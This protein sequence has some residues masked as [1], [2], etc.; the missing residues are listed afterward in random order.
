MPHT[1][2]DYALKLTNRQRVTAQNQ[3]S[4]ATRDRGRAAGWRLATINHNSKV[5]ATP[6]GESRKAGFVLRAN[7]FSG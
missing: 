4:G 7:G 1:I 6:Y 3:Y 5:A 2:R